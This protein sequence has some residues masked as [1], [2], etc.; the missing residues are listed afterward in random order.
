MCCSLLCNK[1]C[2]ECKEYSD[3]I[4]DQKCIS[5]SNSKHYLINGNCVDKCPDGYFMIDKNCEKCDLFCKTCEKNSSNCTSCMDKYYL[6]KSS[7]TYRCK[8]CSVYCDSYIK[9]EEDD[10]KNCLSCDKNSLFK[11]LYNKNCLEQCP[12]IQLLKWIMYI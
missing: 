5:C 10:I 12:E 1:N 11:Y 8:K 6:D 9:G 4:Y 3:D 2:R 7:E